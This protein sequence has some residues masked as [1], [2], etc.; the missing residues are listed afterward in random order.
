MKFV[1]ALFSVLLLPGYN[2][3]AQVFDAANLS[4]YSDVKA[5]SVGDVVTVLIVETANASRES[6]KNSSS[7]SDV[8][9]GGSVTGDLGTL[10]GFLPLFGASGSI[11]NSY[12]GSDGTEQKDRLTGKISATII[13]KN[14]NG[15]LKISG[16]RIIEVN[17]ERN[18]MVIEGVVRSRDIMTDNTI[19]SYNIADAKIIYKKDG[20][21]NKIMKP[22]TIQRWSTLLLAVGL[23]VLA[24]AGTS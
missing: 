2:F 11:S 5:H 3:K 9:A 16:K 19:Y 6:K 14:E 21:S 24:V 8:S 17:G 22:G 10:M 18:I 20:L 15:M 4:I 7:N 1:C 13:E 12:D 23:V